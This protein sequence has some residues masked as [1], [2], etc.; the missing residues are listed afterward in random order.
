MEV[1]ISLSLVSNF[2]ILSIEVT[3]FSYFSLQR[4]DRHHRVLVRC[5][6]Y[7]RLERP[8]FYV[9][10]SQGST[11]LHL[12]VL[13]YDG[14]NGAKLNSKD[15]FQTYFQFSSIKTVGYVRPNYKYDE[16]FYSN[17]V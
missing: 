14:T 11:P 13:E 2:S 16:C 4:H 10:T 9:R 6:D 5:R 8:F 1:T 17:H 3:F 12:K 7:Q 15:D